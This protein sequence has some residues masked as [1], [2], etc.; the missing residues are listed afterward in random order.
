MFQGCSSLFVDIPNLKSSK[1]TVEGGIPLFCE[2]ATTDRLASYQKKP[3]T[4]H[5]VGMLTEKFKYP[6]STPVVLSI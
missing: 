2:I 1:D 6:L 3:A 4:A 5:G